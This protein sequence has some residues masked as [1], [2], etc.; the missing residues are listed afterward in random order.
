MNVSIML[1]PTTQ[2]PSTWTHLPL[3]QQLELFR[4]L[5][6]GGP[7]LGLAE[8]GHE[9]LF[10]AV[11]HVLGISTDV[12][13]GPLFQDEGDELVPRVPKQVLNVDFAYKERRY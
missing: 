2:T 5:D 12:D 8:H 3:L 1:L 4:A 10:D 9:L 7:S 13:V 6:L 11:R